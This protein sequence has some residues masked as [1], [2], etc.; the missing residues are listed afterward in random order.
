MNKSKFFNITIISILLYI[1]S[2]GN[3]VNAVSHDNCKIV[4]GIQGTL[5]LEQGEKVVFFKLNKNDV[6]K[7]KCY[8][9]LDFMLETS[10]NQYDY[11]MEVLLNKNKVKDID[12][13]A[14]KDNRKNL[15]VDIPKEYFKD[16]YNKLI[17]K[18]RPKDKN[19]RTSRKDIC[20]IYGES[21]IHIEL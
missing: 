2:F 16:G 5:P 17:I 7:D 8:V 1:L 9:D 19:K 20:K 18:I 21:Y 13:T 3:L 6:V 14:A 10:D 15:K 4:R 11:V 12:L